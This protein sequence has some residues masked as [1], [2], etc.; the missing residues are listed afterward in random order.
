MITGLCRGLARP[1]NLFHVLGSQQ[2]K[3][4]TELEDTARYA[5]LLLAPARGGDYFDFFWKKPTFYI[6]PDGF[7]CGLIYSTII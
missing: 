5:G 6:R 1:H 4:L 3:F 2:L 7:E